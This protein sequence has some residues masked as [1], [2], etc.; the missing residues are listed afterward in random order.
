MSSRGGARGVGWVFLGPLFV[1]VSNVE[2]VIMSFCFSR[3]QQLNLE[4]DPMS[5]VERNSSVH[6]RRKAITTLEDGVGARV[7]FVAS[8]ALA[9]SLVRFTLI[10]SSHFRVRC[11]SPRSSGLS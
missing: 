7:A 8:V 3:V 2:S 5:N 11:S 9:F 4:A 10:L 1:L 6:E